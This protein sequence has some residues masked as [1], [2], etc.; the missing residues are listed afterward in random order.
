M[1][2]FF[3]AIVTI[4]NAERFQEYAQKSAPTFGLYDGEPLIKGKFVGTF[5]GDAQH[6]TT[7]VVK[8]PDLEK[9][10]GWYA[11]PEYQA[12][13]ALRDEACD[14]NIMKYQVPAA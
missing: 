6:N 12:L 4:K 2:A 5:C 8:F 13:I 9:L 1:S 10:E 14:M 3:V 11:S 7:A